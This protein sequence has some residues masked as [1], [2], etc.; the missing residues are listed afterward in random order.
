MLLVIEDKDDPA[1]QIAEELDDSE[2][3][4]L[5]Y[6]PVIMVQLECDAQQ[7]KLKCAVDRMSY[8]H[9]RNQTEEVP[10]PAQSEKLVPLYVKALSHIGERPAYLSPSA[11]PNFETDLSEN[12]TRLYTQG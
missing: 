1:G 10:T 2:G 3:A 5:A 6:I 12:S 4:E 8:E 9:R 11:I 7:A